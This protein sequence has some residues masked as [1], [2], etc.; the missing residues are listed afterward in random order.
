MHPET[1]PEQIS[2]RPIRPGEHEAEAAVVRAANNAGVYA[3]EL[4]TNADWLATERDSG[5]RNEQ[6]VVLVAERSTDGAILGS[7]TLLRG[8]AR[9]AKLAREGES[10]LRFVSVLPSAAGRGLGS[11][12][13]RAALERS[14][15]WGVS[16]LR[17]DTGARNPAQRLYE[18]IG[19]R[20]T[21]ALEDTLA[22][23]GYGGS[24]SYEFPLQLSE[25]HV[26]R[27]MLPHETEAVRELCLAAYL[28]DYEWIT[29]DYASEIGDVEGRAETQ[30]V[31]V[32][33]HRE[34][35]ALDASVTTGFAGQ[36]VTG[37][38]EPGELDLRL[39]AVHPDARGQGLGET[40]MRHVLLLAQLRAAPT[41]ML[42]TG[43]EMLGAQALYARLGFAHRVELD[44]QVTRPDGTSYTL[45]TYRKALEA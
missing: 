4:A 34:T 10:E 22:D 42:H 1:T 12:L 20:R 23:T 31:W 24:V 27:R 28:G 16:R 15:E 21:P 44:E 40:M 29:P 9:Y 19:F 43:T 18:R 17:L 41:V 7:A 6:G 5:G 25:T 38:A 11:Q 37:M 26:F 30:Q 2:I 14:L 8:G 36:S 39:L 3:A 13:T 33:E 45:L 32:A 35:G